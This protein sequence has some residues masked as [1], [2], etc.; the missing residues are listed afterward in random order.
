MVRGI[1]ISGI[2]LWILFAY[3]VDVSAQNTITVGASGADYTTI[4]DAV[5]A[6]A[7]N[8][9][10]LVNSGTY[11]DPVVITEA[12]GLTIKAADDADPVIDG[13]SQPRGTTLL[14]F[15]PSTDGAIQHVRIE[16]LT[17]RN[18][19]IPTSGSAS[20]GH[21]IGM[22][23]MISIADIT[24]IDNTFDNTGATTEDYRGAAIVLDNVDGLLIEN[25]NLLDAARYGSATPEEIAAITLHHFQRSNS[26]SDVTVRGNVIN[27]ATR[28]I[29]AGRGGPNS[30]TV[31]DNMIIEDNI[32]S[33]IDREGVRAD[34]EAAS[35][36]ET[37]VIRNNEFIG[38]R[39]TIRIGHSDTSGGHTMVTD[40]SIYT[41]SGHTDDYGVRVEGGAVTIEDNEITQKSI[42]VIAVSNAGTLSILSNEFGNN[43]KQVELPDGLVSSI[44]TILAENEFDRSVT[45]RQPDGTIAISEILSNIQD[46]IDAADPG[47][48][49]RVMAGIYDEALT[50]GKSLSLLGANAGINP[51]TG[52]RGVETVLSGNGSIR[53]IGSA[54]DVTIDGFEFTDTPGALAYEHGVILLPPREDGGT[55]GGSLFNVFE[56]ISIRNNWFHDL[57]GRPVF[58]DCFATYDGLTISNN[59]IE[60]VDEPGEDRTGIKI[61]SRCQAG[62][63]SSGL[64]LSGNIINGT[65]YAGIIVGGA[66]GVTISDNTITNVP[67]HGIN[68][69]AG[70]DGSGDVTISGNKIS[71]TAL[72]DGSAALR[73]K[74]GTYSGSIHIKENEFIDSRI[75][76][77]IESGTVV[78]DGIEVRN[79]NLKGNLDGALVNN[80]SLLI[81]AKSN[82][83]GISSGPSGE[84]VTG[85]VD[86][87]E[88]CIDTDCSEFADPIPYT[89]C[90]LGCP[91]QNI[92]D[93]VDVADP[94]DTILIGPDDYSENVNV[95]T[96]GLTL[97]SDAGAAIE[98]QFNL[99]APDITV[100]GLDITNPSGGYGIVAYGVGGIEISNN[101]IRDIGTDVSWN[102]SAQGIYVLDDDGTEPFGDITITGN[103]ISDIGHDQGGSSNKGIFIGDSQAVPTLSNVTITDNTIRNVTAKSDAVYA[104]GGRGAYGIQVNFGVSSS[105]MTETLL[106]DNNTISGLTGFWAHGIGLESNTPDVTVTNNTIS[107]LQATK[108]VDEEG[109]ETVNN[110]SETPAGSF[111]GDI[112]LIFGSNSSSDDATVENNR[113]SDTAWGVFL[114]NS[115]DVDAS[116]NWWGDPKGPGAD[117]TQA[118]FGVSFTPWFIDED[119]TVL[120]TSLDADAFQIAIQP[121]S[122]TAG[123]PIKGPPS[124]LVTN[125]LDDPVTEINVT[126]SLEDGAEF[127]GG[128]LTIP[129]DDDGTAQFSDLVINTMG[130]YTLV[131]EVDGVDNPVSSKPFNVVAGK[132]SSLTVSN[133]PAD[134]VAGN[135]IGGPPTVMVQD[136]LGNPVSKAK[137]TVTLDNDQSLDG[138]T[139]TKTTISDGTV[140]FSDIL[141]NTAGSYR[142][143]FTVAGSVTELSDEFLL[144][145]DVSVPSAP[146]NL[147]A[148]PGNRQVN[149]SWDEPADNGGEPITG[150]IVEYSAGPN[151]NNWTVF[152]GESSSETSVTVT[153]LVN[154]IRHRFRVS[155]VNS[156]GTGPASELVSAVPVAPIFEED[157]EPPSPL[158][159]GGA[160][161]IVGGVE[162]PVTKGLTDSGTLELGGEGFQ[163]SF[164]SVGENGE[165]ES[166][167]TENDEPV[168][169][170]EPGGTLK[171]GGGGFSPGSS[172]AVWLFSTPRLL[173]FVDVDE[174]GN[175][176]GEIPIPKD[177]EVRSHTL[178]IQG[179]GQSG[180]ER[181]LALGVQV[182][183]N[184]TTSVS[185][186]DRIITYA[187]SNG[188]SA[189]PSTSDFSGLGILGVTTESLDDILAIISASEAEEVDTVPKIRV[190]VDQ[191]LAELAFESAISRI[192]SWAA[193]GGTGD[194]P[195]V[196]DYETVEVT[197]VTEEN[198]GRVNNAVAEADEEEAGS[199]ETIQMIVDEVL[200]ELEVEAALDRIRSWAASD[201]TGEVPDLGD[202]VRIGVT[203]V[204]AVNINRVNSAVVEADEEEAATAEMIQQIVD[205]VLALLEVEEA[206]GTIRTYAEQDGASEVPTRDDYETAGITG[207][208]EENLERVNSAIADADEEDTDS[209]EKIQAIVDRVLLHLSVTEYNLLQNYPNPFRTST[210]VE[211]HV[212]RQADVT[213]TVYDIL[214]RPVHTLI[215]EPNHAPGI[216]EHTWDV[217]GLASGVYIYRMTAKG[218]DGETFRKDLKLALF[219]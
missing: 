153:D 47:Q 135:V 19:P 24:I 128:T 144:E 93:A 52:V 168:F 35:G 41:E 81:D 196:T 188:T 92:Q 210:T 12:N 70:N 39:R 184:R 3:S 49:V 148:E 111:R 8:S 115:P 160:V 65:T 29:W 50:I 179:V 190:I 215:R 119:L 63:P 203:G 166:I 2:L 95:N 42:G 195:A 138:G 16:G 87:G 118:G 85:K 214:G 174:N 204:T 26:L 69:G 185:A 38:T 141:I 74:A 197:G 55:V 181:M 44:S 209:P 125:S 43:G 182:K 156:I 32:F 37:I 134:G 20:S 5:D 105:G 22:Y 124:I 71:N 59:R 159:P 13:S 84:Q 191:M 149:L 129:T 200:A 14:E 216:Y 57:S 48:T 164:S 192:R 83:W 101:T 94:E 17:F 173:G 113:F 80:S 4:Q 11:P 76:L 202:Y 194:A 137:V 158:P 53:L 67:E 117:A 207:V 28:G 112:A 132:A 163:M 97:T 88:W 66:V 130:S 176:I 175:F 109:D 18:I 133:Q 40:N 34:P 23:S 64:T 208:T 79:N 218:S 143:A 25:N 152:Q 219:K 183:P 103:T 150:Y 157:E 172:V 217:N 45:I 161:T 21:G 167:S 213:I 199:T 146:L 96:A 142:L 120:S 62:T 211:Y 198:L 30:N 180:E 136:K 91:F 114:H 139:L 99:F 102:F 147:L 72:P 126:V 145:P 106:I 46:G 104:D 9:V 155:A 165:Q 82:W 116:R 68:L 121:S 123:Q 171:T 100:T 127:D 212:L 77:R 205:E 186:L 1:T 27:G 154:N 162:V 89:V 201:G 58:K 33:N 170:F 107:N 187:S 108:V 10:I 56:N 177:I 61:Q 73:I 206:L 86:V 31:F 178:R 90:A 54:S 140:Q 60:N 151:G 7:D 122:T 6:A 189:A 75:G 51:N 193:G 169:N 36:D 110:S 15:S 98:G 78:E 131:F